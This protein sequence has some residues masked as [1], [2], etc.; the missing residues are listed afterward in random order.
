MALANLARLAAGKPIRWYPDPWYAEAVKFLGGCPSTGFVAV[1]IA[2]RAMVPDVLVLYGFDATKPGLP[3]WDDARKPMVD[4]HNFT[5]EKL[6]IAALRDRQE[7][8]GE[9]W[10]EKPPVV[11]WPNAPNLKGMA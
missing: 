3:G 7:W 9:P 10:W 2:V 5:K 11:E 8:L 4:H 1:D 6:T